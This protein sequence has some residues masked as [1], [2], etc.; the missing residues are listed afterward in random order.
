MQT[1]QHRFVQ[2]NGIRMYVAEQG[3]D[4]WWCCA[5]AFQRA[6]IRGGTS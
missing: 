1:P 6:G 4:H 5:T 2:A 3:E